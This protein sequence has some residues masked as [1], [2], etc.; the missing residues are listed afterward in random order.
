MAADSCYSAFKHDSS[1]F[2]WLSATFIILYMHMPH[3]WLPRVV[4]Q[5]N[6]PMVGLISSPLQRAGALPGGKLHGLQ[7]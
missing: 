7:K 1:S 5:S 3:C 2:N 4:V 6:S